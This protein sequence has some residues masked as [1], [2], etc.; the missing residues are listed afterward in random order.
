MDSS[1]Q[2]FSL[3]QVLKATTSVLLT[4]VLMT[5]L[6]F[7]SPQPSNQS[8]EN[9]D[10]RSIGEFRSDLKV[11]M[12]LSKNKD[13]Q[14]QR[15][16]IFNLCV[17]H[18][19]L[20]RHPEFES[21][22]IIQGFRMTAAQ[23]MKKFGDDVAKQEARLARKTKPNSSIEQDI[24]GFDAPKTSD[25]D[26]NGEPSK[27]SAEINIASSMSHFS[28][29]QFSGGPNQ[30]FNYAGGRFAPPWD[31][32]PELVALIEN[33]IHPSTWRRNGGNGNIH[34]FRPVRALVVSSTQE[35]NDDM[36]DLMRKLRILNGIQV[37]IGGGLSGSGN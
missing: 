21:N 37:Q 10:H 13:E 11:F 17:L 16:A 20:V 26:S 8:I 2:T 6:G 7:S 12:K 14:I 34:Y 29:G 27:L 30:L 36:V 25:G 28:M 33:T 4:A 32:G 23:R 1:I 24:Q 22:P 9:D 35:A 31:H 15:N 3:D 18:D 5:A 19:E